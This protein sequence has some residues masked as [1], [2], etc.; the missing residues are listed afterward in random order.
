MEWTPEWNNAVAMAIV[1]ALGPLA[2]KKHKQAHEESKRRM[3]D[4]WLKYLVTHEFCAR[5]SKQSN[6]VRVIG[7]QGP[8]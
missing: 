5:H 3:K 4:G 6:Q 7:K 1:A 2:I 8:D